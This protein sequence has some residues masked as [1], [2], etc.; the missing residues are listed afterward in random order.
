MGLFAFILILYLSSINFLFCD[1]PVNYTETKNLV[2]K[3]NAAFAEEQYDE[4]VAYFSSVEEYISENPEYRDYFDHHYRDYS[5]IDVIEERK[6]LGI[7]SPVATHNVLVFY[8]EKTDT[9]Y[10]GII[11][12]ESFT[13][14]MK[15]KQPLFL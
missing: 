10:D 13:E 15:I 3:G 7:I 6:A 4:A 9:S 14:E 5:M 8:I 12:Q 1:T 2:Q 11:V